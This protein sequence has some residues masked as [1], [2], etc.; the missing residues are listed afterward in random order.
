MDNYER[1]KR[2]FPPI[3]ND[4][5][6]EYGRNDW[7]YLMGLHGAPRPGTVDHAQAAQGLG[8]ILLT[9]P[10]TVSAIGF[11]IGGTFFHAAK[12]LFSKNDNNKSNSFLGWRE[13]GVL[14]NT[15]NA[16][17]PLIGTY[18][19]FKAN[20]VT[21][22]EY[23]TLAGVGVTGSLLCA[24][25]VAENLQHKN[26]RSSGIAMIF[27]AASAAA[28]IGGLSNTRYGTWDIPSHYVTTDSLKIYTAPRSNAPL[29]SQYSLSA[30]TCIHYGRT[31]NNGWASITFPNVI[32]NMPFYIQYRG[33]KERYVA[34]RGRRSGK[35]CSP[36]RSSRIQEQLREAKSTLSATKDTAVTQQ[37]ERRQSR[38]GITDGYSCVTAQRGVNFRSRPRIQSDNIIS[39]IK[40]NTAVRHSGPVFNVHWQKVEVNGQTGYIH[41]DYLRPS[42]WGL[43]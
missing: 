4:P 20:E 26:L 1:G 32:G 13:N 9:L 11:G 27:C 3:S 24:S 43:C 8:M 29:A 36:V 5:H 38:K 7:D 21:S 25:L 18:V 23:A 33:Y 28:T 42:P 6:S 30:G 31:L 16:I 12:K 2:G 17:S 14:I 19:G 35:S 34:L 40:F 10:A 15:I 41:K 39:S 22:T 37:P